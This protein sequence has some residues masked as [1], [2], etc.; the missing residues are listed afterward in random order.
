MATLED[1]INKTISFKSGDKVRTGKL[2]AYAPDWIKIQSSSDPNIIEFYDG[3]GEL[4]LPVIQTKR[5]KTP[6]IV[7]VAKAN[8]PIIADTETSYRTAG[9]TWSASYA[10][11][12]Y[13]D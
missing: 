2:I 12:V 6:T 3:Y 10:I 5:I 13:P 11:N 1:Y 8:K 7:F 9:L 4:R